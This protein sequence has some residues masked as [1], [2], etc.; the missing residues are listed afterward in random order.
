MSTEVHGPRGGWRCALGASSASSRSASRLNTS[1][2]PARSGRVRRGSSS[3]RPA[4]PG[5]S[6]FVSAHGR[7]CSGRRR[8]RRGTPECWRAMSLMNSLD[9]SSRRRNHWDDRESSTDSVGDFDR[10]GTMN[11]SKPLLG[12]LPRRRTWR[13]RRRIAEVVPH[14]ASTMLVRTVRLLC[15]DRQSPAPIQPSGCVAHLA[16][17][18]ARTPAVRLAITGEAVGHLAR[19]AEV[20]TPSLADHAGVIP[21]QFAEQGVPGRGPQRPSVKKAPSQLLE[22]GARSTSTTTY[23][24]AAFTSLTT[25][26]SRQQLQHPWSVS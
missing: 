8:A 11:A 9:W 13:R 10:A 3:C 24:S 15:P 14:H 5:F 26:A 16:R 22:D 23:Q 17:G 2:S 6:P 25:H 1:M 21:R 4:P 20:V 19:L 18:V 7:R 12:A